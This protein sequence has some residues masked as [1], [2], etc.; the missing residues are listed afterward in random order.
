MNLKIKPESIGKIIL[1][2]GMLATLS[3][4]SKQLKIKEDTINTEFNNDTINNYLLE[5]NS[6]L[7][8]TKPILWIHIPRELNARKHN[9]FG[10]PNSTDLNK[11][12]IYLTI[13]SIIQNCE[14]SFTICLID[15]NSFQKLLPGWDINLEKIQSPILDNVRNMGLLKLLYLYGGM[16]CPKSFL[17]QK[18][19]IDFYNLS[20]KQNQIISFEKQNTGLSFDN[21]NYIPN[22]QFIST[23]PQNDSIKILSTF[24]EELISTD[25]THE[26]QFLERIGMQYEKLVQSSKIS[27]QNGKLIGIKTSNNKDVHLENLM[28]SDFVDFD[29]EKYGILIPD[30][31]K[32]KYEWFIYLNA[33][34][35]MSSDTT[36]GKQFLI[37]L[38]NQIIPPKNIKETPNYNIKNNNL[39]QNL[40][41]QKMEEIINANIGHWETPLGAPVWGLKP[42]NLGDHILK[43]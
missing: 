28:S 17:C 8:S 31:N 43:K 1:L 22:I 26:T 11:P 6:L 25:N 10:S 2:L 27:K 40:S 12:Y 36:I 18:D 42:N 9:N 21:T 35:I 37:T 34:E 19:L 30:I 15:D 7:K 4:V 41:Q 24:M 33:H 38:G 3:Y 39:T 20:L 16:L 13:R 23:F 14:N 32:R 5:Q 29:N